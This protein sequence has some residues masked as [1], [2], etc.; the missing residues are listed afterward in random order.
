MNSQQLST[1][2]W[3]ERIVIAVMFTVVGS[4]IIIVF[5]QYRPMLPGFSDTLG[6]LGVILFLFISALLARRNKLLN[7][8][9][10]M[11]FGLFVMIFAVS[12]DWWTAQ[13][14]QDSLGGFPNSPVGLALEKF[15]TVVVVAL[16]IVLSTRFTGNSLGSVYLQRGDL[17]RGL[18][19]GL[20][21]FGICVA[22]AIPMS[23]L[24]FTGEDVS[25]SELI[26]WAPWI[27]IAVLGNAAN[28]ELLFRGLFLRKLEPFFGKLLSNLL[29]VF[30]FTGLHL[31]VTYTQDQMI[32]LAVVVPLS[33]AWGYIMQKTD[34]AWGSILFHAGTDIP[35]FLAIFSTRF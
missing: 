15:K 9:W 22:G 35:I 32:F 14:V 13:F 7:P 25:L 24:M 20:I 26:V 18:T 19:I 31:G 33:L 30:V 29:I 12:L 3:I 11:I 5:S 21:A 4:F 23:K 16:V 10:Q 27:L 28:E 6:R 2:E 17:K 1:K 8:Y 34:S